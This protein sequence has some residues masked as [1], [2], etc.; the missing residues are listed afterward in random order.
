MET[1]VAI[2]V[3][4]TSQ[5]AKEVDRL[6]QYTRR[7]NVIVR[8]VFLPEEETN[9]Q[10]SIKMMKMIKIDVKLPDVVDEVD[11]LHRV[12][13]IKQ[14]NGKK[15]QDII[16]KFKSHAA[17]YSVYNERKKV[18][19]IKIA[20]NLTKHRGNLLFDAAQAMKDS[21]K[22]NFVFAD[23]HGDLQI[24]LNEPHKGSHVFSFYSL[25][26]ILPNIYDDVY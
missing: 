6:S 12:G 10:V 4:V 16:I 22:V 19:N 23:A 26:I 25:E 20:P 7:S 1:D 18:R 21:P 8:N 3:N 14:L 11:K 24:R 9:E 5:L 13:R 17:R 15:T 2:S